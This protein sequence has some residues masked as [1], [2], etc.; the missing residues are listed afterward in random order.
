MIDPS[1]AK[2]INVKVAKMTFVTTEP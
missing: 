1:S 2:K